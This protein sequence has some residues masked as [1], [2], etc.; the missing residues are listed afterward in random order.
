MRRRRADVNDPIVLH[1]DRP[2]MPPVVR[3][4]LA[5]RLHKDERKDITYISLLSILLQKLSLQVCVS[6]PCWCMFLFRTHSACFQVDGDFLH[7]LLDFVAGLELSAVSH[8][9]ETL[10]ATPC[11]Q[12]SLSVQTRGIVMQDEHSSRLL[13]QHPLFLSNSD[14]WRNLLTAVDSRFALCLPL[15]SFC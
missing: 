7:Q 2:L 1:P 5:L 10:K 9:D 11:R 13:V 4:V 12:L 14:V 3:D 15:V 8:V 6:L